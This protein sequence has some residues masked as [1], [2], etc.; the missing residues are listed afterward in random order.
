MAA[1]ALE[2]GHALLAGLLDQLAAQPQGAQAQRAAHRQ[3]A[4]VEV[5]RAVVLA[6]EPAHRE[7]AV[8][9]RA[10]AQLGAG[11]ET[12]HRLA[13]AGE[14]RR[15]A[16]AEGQRVPRSPHQFGLEAVV[17]VERDV[18]QRGLVVVVAV[19]DDEA[20]AHL[21]VLPARGQA[22]AA[23]A[24]VGEADRELVHQPVTGVVRAVVVGGQRGHDHAARADPQP[25]RQAVVEPQAGEALAPGVVLPVGVAGD[26]PVGA[27]VGVVHVVVRRGG[28]HP[29]REPRRHRRPR[30]LFL[31]LR[32]RRPGREGQHGAPD[33]Q[34]RER[35]A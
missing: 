10:P 11:Q 17:E 24:G 18:P 32:P 14:R 35:P 7:R 1:A 5:R 22:E 2:V 33:R 16:R 30:L 27:E 25:L 19:A 26:A 21:Q 15:Q 3:G 12:L 8:L 4:G 13:L 28:L 9:P 31:L 29:V 20:V 34:P 23:P 6:L